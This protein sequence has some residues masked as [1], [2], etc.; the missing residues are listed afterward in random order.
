MSHTLAL[1][2]LYMDV[3]LLARVPD[4]CLCQLQGLC[5][6]VCLAELSYVVSGHRVFC[7]QDG[8]L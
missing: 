4:L 7:R 6:A 2:A 3:S 1:S 5:E 8:P